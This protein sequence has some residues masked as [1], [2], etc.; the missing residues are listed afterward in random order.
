MVT[1]RLDERTNRTAM[2]KSLDG[3]QEWWKVI[4]FSHNTAVFFEPDKNAFEDH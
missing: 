4:I 2:G 1:P 3:Y